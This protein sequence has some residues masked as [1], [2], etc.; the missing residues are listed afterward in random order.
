[1]FLCSFLLCLFFPCA[2]ARRLTQ[3]TSEV[4]L[5]DHTPNKF[6][7]RHLLFNSLDFEL[8]IAGDLERECLEEVCT[9]EESREILENI[10]ETDAFWQHYIKGHVNR[11]SKLDVPALL[12][13]VIAASVAI[14][15]IA[16]LW[17][18][19]PNA[20]RWKIDRSSRA[21]PRRSNASLIIRRLE[22]LSMQPV[23]PQQDELAPDSSGLPTYE[24]AVA[25]SGPQDAPPP[26]Y[27]GCGHTV[28]IPAVA[29]HPTTLTLK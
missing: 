5:K 15:I 19:R 16:L 9:Y 20:M 2:I 6:L 24:E 12:I 13:G 10:P 3:A 14:V 29:P 26:P 1:M 28:K 21:R 8:F 23:R 25:S 4:F 7:G 18:C 27:P 22:E 11:P 17:C